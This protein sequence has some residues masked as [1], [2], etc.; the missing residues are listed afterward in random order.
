MNQ[1]SNKTCTGLRG[2]A[3]LPDDAQ[4]STKGYPSGIHERNPTPDR[5]PPRSLR[6]SPFLQINASAG[7]LS[8]LHF[9]PDIHQCKHFRF[10]ASFRFRDASRRILFSLTS[11]ILSPNRS[12]LSWSDFIPTHTFISVSH[13]PRDTEGQITRKIGAYPRNLIGPCASSSPT[14]SRTQASLVWSPA[15][16][17]SLAIRSSLVPR[18]F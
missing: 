1:F 14:L 3:S 12:A 10:S 6:P 2:S 18:W 5:S 17:V 7:L 15:A 11:F 13:N 16:P 8:C 9:P 4:T